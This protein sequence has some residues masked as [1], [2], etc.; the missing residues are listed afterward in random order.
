MNTILFEQLRNTAD[1]ELHPGI[2]PEVFGNFNREHDLFLPNDH[3][4]VLSKSNGIEAYAGYIRL[5]GL[6]TTAS[7]DALVW[8]HT[9]YWKFAWSD[10]CSGFWCFAETGWGDQYAYALEELRDGN[11]TEKKVYFLD[12]LTMN[13]QLVA[14]S[15]SEFFEREFVR[16]ASEPYDIMIKQARQR[17]GPLKIS[18]HLIYVPSILLGG[19]EAMENVRI[20]NARTAMIYNGDVSTQLLEGL[21]NGAVTSVE[22]YEDKLGRMRLRVIWR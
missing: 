14:S 18:S 20:M 10:R 3:Q 6:Q 16:S 5:F 2:E 21:E 17:F 4:L 9:D 15:F 1:V 13:S 7:I 22:P 19:L 11:T 8:N 12:A